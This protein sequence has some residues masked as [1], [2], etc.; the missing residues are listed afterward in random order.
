MTCQQFSHVLPPEIDNA[1]CRRHNSDL[2]RMSDREL[3]THYDVHGREEGRTVSSG[4]SRTWFAT[5]LP[6]SD[7]LEIGPFDCPFLKGERVRY[8]DLMDRN[9]LASRAA[10]LGRRGQPPEIDY[11]SS[12]GD[13]GIVGDSLFDVVFSAHVVEHQPDLIHHFNEV[14]R[15]LRH[16]GIYVAIIP[17][18]RYCFDH[19]IRESTIADVLD[20]HAMKARSHRLKSV[21]E[22][23]ALTCHN[24]SSRHW[25]G[26]HGVQRDCVE[27]TRAA[28]REYETAQGG[29]VDVHAWQF[30]PV[31]FREL[32]EHL[33]QL[34]LSSLRPI[35]VYGTVRNQLEFIAVLQR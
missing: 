31:Q 22:H 25:A 28:I 19:F 16:G 27:S 23:R 18:K 30:Q 29:Y 24:D 10:Q 3:A 4:Q 15:I 9:G 8:F 13:L 14:A 21:I 7:C 17:D 6:V 34:G 5:H 12:S 26:D 1:V 20:A 11:V 35:R 33:V 2:A 32:T